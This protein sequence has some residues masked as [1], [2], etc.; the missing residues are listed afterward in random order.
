MPP[1]TLAL[2]FVLQF[3]RDKQPDSYLAVAADRHIEQIKAEYALR[4]QQSQPPQNPVRP[5]PATTKK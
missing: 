1:E 5:E 3:I 2:M 4:T